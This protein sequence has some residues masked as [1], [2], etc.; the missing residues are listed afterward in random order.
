M[1]KIENIDL[2][3]LVQ[4]VSE[5]LLDDRRKMAAGIIKK[6]LQKI[7][8]LIID[9]KKAEREVKS[10]QE[11]LKKAQEKIDKIKSGDWSCLNESNQ[12]NEQGK[13]DE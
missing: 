3:N 2:N 12:Q 13:Q 6:E 5:Q 7:E 8:Q 4:E 10:K 11:K 9:I 1:E